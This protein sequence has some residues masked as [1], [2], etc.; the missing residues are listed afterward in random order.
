MDEFDCL[1]YSRAKNILVTA[2]YFSD[3]DNHLLIGSKKV[4]K[5]LVLF[6][7]GANASTSNI[8]VTATL[9]LIPHYIVAA[10]RLPTAMWYWW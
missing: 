5:H 2:P 4:A 1:I 3:F 6:C 10:C 9:I 8:Q 7:L